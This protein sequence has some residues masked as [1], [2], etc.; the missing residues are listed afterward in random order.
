MGGSLVTRP[1][2]FRVSPGVDCGSIVVLVLRVRDGLEDLDLITIPLQTGTPVTAFFANFDDITAP[3]LPA[4]WTTSSTADHQLWRTSTARP[5]SGPNALFSPAPIQEGVNEVVSPV[6]QINT[7]D[8]EVSFRHWYELETTFL[9]NRLYDG[10]VLE[11]KIGGGEWTDILAAGG[12]FITGGY[13][14]TIDS[15][16]ANPLAGRLGW[17]GRSGV[18]QVA[19]FINTK[20]RLPASAAGNSVRLR[21]RVGT[22]I[23]T[24]RE[25]QYIDDLRVTDGYACTCKSS[26]SGAAPFDFD[27]DGKTDLSL[28]NLNDQVNASDTRILNSSD[29]TV[30]TYSFGSESDVPVYADYDGD[31]KTDVAVFRPSEGVW[32]ILKSTNGSIDYAHFGISTD[33]P[34]PADYDGDGKA[35]IAIYRD[36]EAVW[37]LLESTA[38]FRAMQFGSP[39]DVPA[40]A[41]FDGDGSADIAVFRPSDGSGM[42]SA[43]LQE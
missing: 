24:F 37:Y 28:Y 11:L 12:S 25:G 18:D 36:S 10:A 39:G 29:L 4:G 21:W 13:D 3:A 38:G 40:P 41:D 34:V 33:R 43:P 26:T 7:P 31:G 42:C 5:K 19:E 30:T 1:F 20:A 9:R 16:C 27:G 17:S 23:G 32:F 14:G 6:F 15:C 35:D 22:D 2:T 8:A